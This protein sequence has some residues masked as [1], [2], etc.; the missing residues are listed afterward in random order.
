[1][2]SHLPEIIGDLLVKTLRLIIQA[3][4]VIV[5]IA[6]KLIIAIL[7]FIASWIENRLHSEKH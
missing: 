2:S 5:L 7:Q 4:L 6:L 1:M 3:L